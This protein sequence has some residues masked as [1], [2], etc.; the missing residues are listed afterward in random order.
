MIAVTQRAAEGLEELWHD[1]LAAGN[2]SYLEMRQDY[3][4]IRA[5][6]KRNGVPGHITAPILEDMRFR[7]WPG[8]QQGKDGK[9]GKHHYFMGGLQRHTL[10]LLRY[11]EKHV[12]EVQD[13]IVMLGATLWHDCGKLLEYDLWFADDRVSFGHCQRTTFGGLV[14]HM[15]GGLA[16]VGMHWGRLVLALGPRSEDRAAHFLHCVAGHH[17]HR[18]WGSPVVPRTKEALIIHQ[19]DMFS[20]MQ[21][22]GVNPA[23]RDW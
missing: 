4:E 1:Q 22:C 16:L 11:V 10:Q 20:V 5:I 19:A 6:T 14:P 3:D 13:P 2:P 23:E 15:T 9:P 8:S 12:N 18:A 21:D 17:G 7:F